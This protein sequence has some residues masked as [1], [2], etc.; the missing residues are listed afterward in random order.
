MEWTETETIEYFAR[1]TGVTVAQHTKIEQTLWGLQPRTQRLFAAAHRIADDS[2]HPRQI[3]E[4]RALGADHPHPLRGYSYFRFSLVFAGRTLTSRVIAKQIAI[5]YDTPRYRSLL[6]D[7]A[8]MTRQALGQDIPA[9]HSNLSL[10][11]AEAKVAIAF[12]GM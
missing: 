11:H 9:I 2:T 6:F 4:Q 8:L 1:L 5:H 10:S 7:L 12:L 3:P